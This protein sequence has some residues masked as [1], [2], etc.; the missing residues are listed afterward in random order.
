MKKIILLS[1]LLLVSHFIFSQLKL[2]SLFTDGMVLQQNTSVAFGG[3]AKAGSTVNIQP[4]WGEK[5]YSTKADKTG[6][7]KVKIP[8][9][10]ASY[11]EHNI[12]IKGEKTIVIH[13]VLVGEVWLCSGQSNMAMPVYG[14]TSQPV[15]GSTEAVF[16]SENS[17]IRHFN[18][19]RHSTTT[20]QT[21]LKG[22]WSKASP[23]TTGFFSAVGY[24][25]SRQLQKTLN[26]PVGIIHSSWGGSTIEAWMSKE[27]IEKFPDKTILTADK[28]IKSQH[29]TPCLLYNGMIHPLVGYGIKGMLW[30]QGESNVKNY[31]QYDSLFI[32]M[33]HDYHTKWGIGEFPI[34]IAQIAP[35]KRINNVYMREQQLLLSQKLENS[36]IVV[37]LDAK[38]PDNIHPANKEIV[39]NR[40]A[41][42]A[43]GKSYGL[44]NIPH[45]SPEYKK[46]EIVNDTINLYFNYAPRGLCLITKQPQQFQISGENR[47]FTTA[48]NVTVSKNI[49]KIWSSEVKKPVAVRYAF[50]DEAEAELF[51]TAGFPVS[52]FRTDN[53]E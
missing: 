45:K 40:F 52:S 23:G 18:I 49:V 48:N 53:W 9:P 4:S 29:Q 19:E 51:S 25:F 32:A 43:L 24:F 38:S 42:L 34:Y 2:S 11:D 44:S 8:T 1:G 12:T 26:V 3:Q 28:D 15:I 20:P 36:G 6:Y 10:E 37:L 27:A 39:G 16:N 22:Q 31:Q 13:N 14:F 35:Y 33:N 17:F 5:S 7:W 50:N 21:E 47:I 41:Y 30:Y 46:M